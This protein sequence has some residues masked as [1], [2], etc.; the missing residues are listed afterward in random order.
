MAISSS[1][2]S[3]DFSACLRSAR[4]WLRPR[5][6]PAPLSGTVKDAQGGVIP[7][8]TV[9][10]ISESQGHAI[11]P[12]DHQRQR[13]LRVSEHRRRHLHDSGRDAVLQDAQADRA[14][15]ESRL[16]HHARHADD[17]DRRHERNRQRQGR[18]AADSDG[19]GREVLL[20]RSGTGR[21]AAAR[22]PQLHRA[23]RARAGRQRRSELA[24]QPVDDGQRQER[25]RRPHASAAA[26]ATTT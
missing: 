6:S 9:T 16:D 17:R 13:R 15:G 1:R 14:R 2:L 19:D 7:G 26:A 18:D 11:G 8:A 10:L 22:Q 5:A 20:D 21:G 3:E 23:A 24:G 4:L 12:G 25:P